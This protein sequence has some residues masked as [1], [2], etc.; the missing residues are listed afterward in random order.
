MIETNLY[1]DRLIGVTES[2]GVDVASQRADWLDQA[3]C[4]Y[5]QELFESGIT[6][7]AL[8]AGCG[9]GGQAY[10]MA[11]A[12]ACVIGVDK[13]QIPR[14]PRE[15]VSFFTQSVEEFP[16]I[17]NDRFVSAMD[18][19]VMQRM[20]HYLQPTDA[21][22]LVRAVY[23][24]LKPGGR[25]YVSASG[26]ESELGDS[27][28]DRDKLWINRFSRISNLMAEKHRILV[29][30]CLYNANDLAELVANSGFE[31]LSSQV[32]PF[33]NVKVSATK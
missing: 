29:P 18:V 1:G 27:Y 14:S 26:L 22:E 19:V 3:A 11:S 8:D 7:L 16:V 15:N 12:G 17:G 24:M 32:S 30:V 23:S 9:L 2:C 25:F 28:P 21:M 20:I 33:G 4:E 6:P 10:R 31:I 13:F 5:L